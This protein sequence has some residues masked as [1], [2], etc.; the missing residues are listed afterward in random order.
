MAT[1][2]Q[3]LT[4]YIPQIQPFQPDLNFYGNVM[5]TRQSRFDT[6]TK[7]INDLY[8]SLL[9][10]PLSRDTNIK[11]R[12]EF[13]K[14]IDNDIKRISGLDLSLKQNEDQALNVFKGFYDDKYMLA[15]MV[16]TK[17]AQAQLQRG[18]N[19]KYCTDAEKCGGQYW[20]QGM[21]KLQYKLDEFKNVSDEE[22]LNFQIGDYDPYFDWKKDAAKKAKD[23]GYE[24]TR[25]AS[26]GKWM[27]KDS[28]GKLVQKPLY[29]FFKSLYGDDPRVQSNYETQAYVSR[30]NYAKGN[31][32][33]FGSEEEAEKDYIMKNINQGLTDAN[34]NLKEATNSYNQVNS[35]YLK[36]DKKIKAGTGLTPQERKIYEAAAQQR[37]A[38]D[39][40]RSSIQSKIDAI[41]K[42]IDANDINSLRKRAD[43]STAT[44]LENQD[45]IG[46]A[47]TLASLSEKR[48]ITGA[49]PY[50]M[51]SYNNK[52]QMKLADHNAMLDVWKMKHKFD[53]D[54]KMA[55]LKGAIKTNQLPTTDSYEVKGAPWSNVQE[56]LKDNKALL[57]DRQRDARNA[58]MSAAT[59]KSS[60]ALLELVKSARAAINSNPTENAG[61][62]Q[63]LQQLGPNAKNIN[64]IEDLQ[65]AIAE[66]K[67]QAISL[68]SGVA[69]QASTKNNPLGDY[70]WARSVLNQKGGII[71]EVKHANEAF[72]ARLN[73]DLKINKSIANKIEASYSEEN[74]AAR[75]AKLLV[76][77]SGFLEG[78]DA[79]VKKYIASNAQ[80]NIYVTEDKAKATYK[81]LTEQFFDEYNKTEGISLM[82]GTGL[83][84]G[85]MISSTPVQF[86]GLD[87]LDKGS[88][89]VVTD[90]INTTNEALVNSG[91]TVIAVGDP[92]K[93]TL[94]KGDNPG[95]HEFLTWFLN[96]SDLTDKS[97]NRSFTAMV[98]NIAAE[99]PTKGA[100]TFK[101]IS[102]EIIKKYEGTGKA[103]KTFFG[104]DLSKGFTVFFDK[105][106]QVNPFEKP[107]GNLETLLRLEGHAKSTGFQ[108]LAG[109]VDWNFDETTNKVQGVWH[110][111]GY[112]AQGEWI[113]SGAKPRVVVDT[114]ISNLNNEIARVNSILQEQAVKNIKVGQDIAAKNVK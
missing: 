17:N 23:Q 100:I 61:A 68:F 19:F 79:F 9:Y 83:A 64:T 51:A 39:A 53:Y 66:N 69:S 45:M 108:D 105:T 8:G 20:E 42:N 97:K 44:A 56:N 46:L 90:I 32:A 50:A 103:P 1:Y 35:V 31:A 96:Q 27:I 77:N 78:E 86:T 57:F 75:H 29:D 30:K 14:A 26:D 52:L 38:L 106:Q 85:G 93:E 10:S 24:V 72:H 5:Q 36:L 21:Q 95:L 111:S 13:F 41:Q 104:E 4:D 87:L 25:S 49:D 110:P 82:Q 113:E 48:E 80:K 11:R 98:S 88:K 2:I 62:A 54:V 37:T 81:A 92:S 7:K 91:T 33:T 94:K 73:H 89:G 6:A 101:G 34:K 99:D 22:S 40:S 43:L 58:M 67:L 15:D 107:M 70:S 59:I 16:K 63:F 47:T 60:A 3:G 84:G 65:K 18:E 102:P 76:S 28:N 12:E 71:D 74:L 109:T 112:N 114:D 55:E